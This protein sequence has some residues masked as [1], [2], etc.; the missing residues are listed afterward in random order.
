MTSN[1]KL[2]FHDM[3]NFE[4]KYDCSQWISHTFLMELFA[5]KKMI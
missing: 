1:F 3:E 4:V 5:L 2:S